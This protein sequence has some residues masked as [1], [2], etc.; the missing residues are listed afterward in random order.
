M[1]DGILEGLAEGVLKLLFRIL[2]EILRFI[3]EIC[4]FYTGEIIIF[5]V[6]LGYKKPRWDYYVCIDTSASMFVILT[7][8]STWIGIAF[9][10][11][12]GILVNQYFW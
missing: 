8:I 10:I 4:C 11:G 7:E 9:W 12:I 2:L 1:L 3:L 6:T 5:L